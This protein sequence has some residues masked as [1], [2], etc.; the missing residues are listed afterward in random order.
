M[1][2][3]ICVPLR[4]AQKIKRQLLDQGVFDHGHKPKK[5]KQHIF[6]PVTRE[7][8][9]ENEVIDAEL[10][11]HK[12][13][14]QAIPLKQALKR[15]LDRTE[16]DK[17]KTAYDT[18]GTIAIIEIP[19]ELEH[20]K[21]TIGDALLESN[22]LIKTVLCKGSRHEGEYRTQAMEH[23]A[24]ERTKVAKYKE[25]DCTLEVN[26]EEVYFSARL[27]TERKRIAK[28]VK[29]G[30]DILVMFSGAAPYPCV[31]SRQTEASHIV[32][33]EI[34][35][36][37]HR[38]GLENVKR[39]KCRNVTLYCDDVRNIAPTLKQTFDRI[40]MPLPKTAE[41]FLDVTLPLARKN[42]II[43][44]YA[45]YHE[46]EFDKAI[47]EIDGYC[48]RAGREYEILDI[49]KAGQHAPRTYRICVDFKLLD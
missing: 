1:A 47:T 35:P 43:H 45:F 3:A 14:L 38:Y 29:E 15:K 22:P 2:R 31:F 16:L 46:D 21:K 26:V 18:V 44:L 40:V 39:N 24:G 28:Q 17:V 10:E 9:G 13:P 30:E 20:R 49:V 6:F 5:D 23:I 33:I 19:D 4:Q 11:E 7:Y 27:S 41:E 48:K 32:G 8:E 34:N 37:G 12:R 36:E 25:N 42:A